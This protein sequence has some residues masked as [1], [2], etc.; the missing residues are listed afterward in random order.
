MRKWFYTFTIFL[1]IGTSLIANAEY[2]VYQ[3]YVRPKFAMP[4]ESKNYLVTSTLDPTSYLAYH[5]GSESLQLELLRS[6][7]CKGHT[8]SGK[9][10]CDA[11]LK[12]AIEQEKP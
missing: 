9:A 6:W 1:G 12:Q 4:G 10:F 5:G 2:R 7:M 11:P 8:G 3:Y